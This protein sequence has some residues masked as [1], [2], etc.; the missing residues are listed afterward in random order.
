[1]AAKKGCAGVDEET[2]DNFQQNLRGNRSQLKDEIATNRYQP[3]P[4]KQVLIPK[5]NGKT[6][7]LRIPTVRDRIVQHALL[8]VLN[9]IAEQTFSDGSFPAFLTK[10]AIAKAETLTP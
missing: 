7:E 5:G 3:L 8:N 2:I 9:P 10:K 1:M 4:C 6:R